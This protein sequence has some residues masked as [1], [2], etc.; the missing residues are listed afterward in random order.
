MGKNIVNMK[1]ILIN[2]GAGFIG[3]NLA[4]YLQSNY[5]NANIIIFDCFRNDELLSNG[6]LLS[7]GH[8][9]NLIGFK[10]EVICGNINNK[11]DLEA[12]NKYNFDFTSIGFPPNINFVVDGEAIRIKGSHNITNKSTKKAVGT[13]LGSYKNLLLDK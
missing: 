5:P 11:D 7:Y 4:H 8:Y 2:G 3:S 12:L 10:G 9:K 13:I 1:N 6:N